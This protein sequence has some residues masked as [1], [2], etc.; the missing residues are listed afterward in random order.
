MKVVTP[1]GSTIYGLRCFVENSSGPAMT[2][3][4]YKETQYAQ[5]HIGSLMVTS[6]ASTNVQNLMR[7]I[8]FIGGA[9]YIPRGVS[10][11]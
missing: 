1:Q 11:I 2:E 6:N 10:S 9:I 4:S 3:K 7:L 8:S 5:N